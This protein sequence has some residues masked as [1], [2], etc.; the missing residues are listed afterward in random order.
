MGEG[1][2]MSMVCLG[3]CLA[4][5]PRVF[6]FLWRVRLGA[7]VSFVRCLGSLC[8]SAYGIACRELV[9]LFRFSCRW[10]RCTSAVIILC[11]VEARKMSASCMFV[12][13]ADMMVCI[14][15]LVVENMGASIFPIAGCAVVRRL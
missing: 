9:F 8:W 10:R 12:R 7:S 6:V 15:L 13:L 14:D 3:V 4:G 1:F 11:M 2:A 5:A